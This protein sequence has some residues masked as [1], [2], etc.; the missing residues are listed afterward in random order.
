MA[1]SRPLK[2]KCA[3]YHNMVRSAFSFS[4]T[5]IVIRAMLIGTTTHAASL[6]GLGDLPGGMFYRPCPGYFRRRFCGCGVQ[7]FGQWIRGVSLVSRW[8]NGRPR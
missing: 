3:G 5:S 2:S 1:V 4:L 7:H 6:H 8:R